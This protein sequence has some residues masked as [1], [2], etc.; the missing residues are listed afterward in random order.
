MKNVDILYCPSQTELTKA[1]GWGVPGQGG[2]TTHMIAYSWWPFYARQAPIQNLT[3][4]D[5]TPLGQL[6]P[7]GVQDDANLHLVSDMVHTRL[8][9]WGGHPNH[10]D[11]HRDA[12]NCYDTAYG[13]NVLYND[14]HVKWV[15]FGQLQRV[16]WTPAAAYGWQC[17]IY[18]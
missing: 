7:S 8:S 16:S 18:Y 2:M 6:C 3:L 11:L 10:S 15:N 13:A 4:D 1:A 14:G 9:S 12:N 17:E 5:G